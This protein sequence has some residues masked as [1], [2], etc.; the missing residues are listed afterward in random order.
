LKFGLLVGKVVDDISVQIIDSKKLPAAVMDPEKFRTICLER[1]VPGEICVSGRHV[2][3]SYYRNE[4]A[5]KENK[6]K[7]QNQIWHRTG[8]AGYLDK[9]NNL[10][11]LGR[12]RQRFETD[13]QMYYVFPFESY[14]ASLE[15]VRAGTVL[16]I[17]GQIY[18]LIE[19][20]NASFKQKIEREI[21]AIKL[22][23]THILRF[24]RLPRDP[25]HNSKIDYD[26]LMERLKEN[27]HV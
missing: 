8:D 21:A 7:V 26:L 14:F 6:I 4:T 10:F 25:R 17:N 13:G 27:K 12:V 11:L 20:H 3:K 5:N 19:L 22:P 24:C 2:L 15:Y 16:N 18:V 9:E 23:F 1:G